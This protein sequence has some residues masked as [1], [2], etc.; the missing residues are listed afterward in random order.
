MQVHGTFRRRSREGGAPP[1]APAPSRSSGSPMVRAWRLCA[2][3]L[4]AP[5][6]PEVSIAVDRGQLQCRAP[7]ALKA[8]VGRTSAQEPVGLGRDSC[9]HTMKQ[10]QGSAQGRPI[11][12]QIDERIADTG[13][14]QS[15]PCHSRRHGPTILRDRGALRPSEANSGRRI[16]LL[17][18][19]LRPIRCTCASWKGVG[20]LPTNREG[21]GRGSAVQQR[22]AIIQEEQ[23]LARGNTAPFD[24]LTP[25]RTADFS[26]A[27]GASQPIETKI[28][29]RVDKCRRQRSAPWTRSEPIPRR[30]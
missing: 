11:L 20:R 18:G 22:S 3:M 2:A 9:A 28:P 27:W 10:I 7:T 24:S 12:K 1:L 21:R 29:L 6:S 15:P 14:S 30:V 8:K 4:G 5:P 23:P 17:R 16:A 19:E 13:R 26:C 25:T